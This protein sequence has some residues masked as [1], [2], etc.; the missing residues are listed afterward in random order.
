MA[1]PL[2]YLPLQGGGGVLV[3]QQ[4]KRE[5]EVVQAL[6][7]QLGGSGSTTE[8]D[9]ALSLLYVSKASGWNKASAAFSLAIQITS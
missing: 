6:C 9:I 4:Y 2:V 5:G 3:L 7:Q 1:N 8:Y